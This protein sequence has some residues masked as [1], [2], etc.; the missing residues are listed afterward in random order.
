MSKEAILPAYAPVPKMTT[1]RISTCRSIMVSLMTCILILSFFNYETIFSAINKGTVVCKSHVHSQE[2]SQ[3][4]NTSLEVTSQTWVIL[5]PEIKSRSTLGKQNS[6]SL[7][8]RNGAV[9]EADVALS[10]DGRSGYNR[11]EEEDGR[12]GYNRR[13]EGGRS[14]YN[15]V[16][17]RRSGYNSVTDGRSGYNRREEEDGRSGYNGVEDGRSGYNHVI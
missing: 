2:I 5:P 9:S 12:S 16:E 7:R 1:S 4:T 11:R 10:A 14:G 13:E 6:F 15:S 17:D 3:P 8:R